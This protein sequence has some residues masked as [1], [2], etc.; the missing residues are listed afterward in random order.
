MVNFRKSSYTS[1]HSKWKQLLHPFHICDF[2]KCPCNPFYMPASKPQNPFA[3]VFNP[4][5]ARNR[6]RNKPTQAEPASATQ[7]PNH[8]APDGSHQVRW[9]LPVLD[10]K[11]IDPQDSSTMQAAEGLILGHTHEGGLATA[12]AAQWA[13]G[14]FGPRPQNQQTSL[15]PS[16]GMRRWR[17]SKPTFVDGGSSWIPSPT[18]STGSMWC[19]SRCRWQLRCRLWPLDMCLMSR[20]RPPETSVH[21]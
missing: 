10:G 1:Y 20:N 5:S 21:R 11:P 13:P 19:R 18:R 15:S 7:G 12:A 4:S 6:I 16:P 3:Y 9:H 8:W 14:S 2:S 17:W